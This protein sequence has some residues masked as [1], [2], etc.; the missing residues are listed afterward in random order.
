[1]HFFS[2]FCHFLARCK[3][4]LA[5][6]HNNYR[7]ACG[8]YLQQVEAFSVMLHAENMRPS[9]FNGISQFVRGVD[10]ARKL[11]TGLYQN[12]QNIIPLFILTWQSKTYRD[13]LHMFTF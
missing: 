3:R 8:P 12:F 11:F 7:Y 5:L 10:R 9:Y 4:L 13:A 2:E 1:M 6:L